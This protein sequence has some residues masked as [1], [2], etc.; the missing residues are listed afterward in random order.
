ML[1]IYSFIILPKI[2]LR[3]RGHSKLLILCQKTMTLFGMTSAVTDILCRPAN[4]LGLFMHWTILSCIQ[5]SL[6]K[7]YFA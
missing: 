5:L 3:P 7:N 1:I 4:D 6:E 2:T